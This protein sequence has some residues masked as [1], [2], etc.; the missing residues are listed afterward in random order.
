MERVRFIQHMGW[1]V[2]LVDC[3]EC[4]SSELHDIFDEAR[5]TITAQPE[6]S[7]LVLSD[8]TGAEFD[9][10]AA[11]HLKVT[12]AYDRPHVRRA[13]IVGAETLPEVYYNNLVSFSAREF[14]VF[15]TRE[16]ALDWLIGADARQAAV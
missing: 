7:V 5:E 8:F 2:L 9:K 3:S 10:K 1:Q 12:A 15:K 13:A 16:E 6:K 4:S 11:D 14:P